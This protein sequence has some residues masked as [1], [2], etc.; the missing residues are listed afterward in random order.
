MKTWKAVYMHDFNCVTSLGAD[1]ES[2]WAS[3]VAGESGIAAQDVGFLKD[4]FV[5]KIPDTALNSF[6]SAIETRLEKILYK[7]AVQ[8]VTKY[9]PTDRTAFILATTKGNISA[10]HTGSTT[11][12]SLPHLA[13]ILATALGVSTEPIV[14]SHACVSGVVALS[15]AK[16]L[17]QMDE[18]DDAIVLAGDEIGDFVVSGFQAFQAISPFPCKPFDKNRAGVSLGEAG[19]CVYVSTRPSAFKIVGESAINDANHISGPSRTGEGLYRS[20]SAALHEAGLQ[21][22]D[23]DYVSAHGTATAYNDEMEAIAF[24]R[25]GVSN[26]PVSSLKGV[27]GHTLGASGLLE[28]VIGLKCMEQSLLIPT[29]GFEELGVS[30]PLQVLNELKQQPIKYF[31][32]TASGF[33][34]SNAALL[35]ENIC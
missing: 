22:K 8:I 13:R 12:A 25:L 17:L 33:G 24:S 11:Q 1:V 6:H 4:V 7:A 14:V 2:N 29:R 15:V 19:A 30:Q 28:V 9:R 21:A 31:L 3:L 16:R 27:Y 23:I 10:L 32:K 18:Y 5:S 34:G 20:V 35:I 26:V